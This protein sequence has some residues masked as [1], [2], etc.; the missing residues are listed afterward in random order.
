MSQL[1]ISLVHTTGNP[2]S[3]NAAQSLGQAA[4]LHE[5]I[6]TFGYG[7][8]GLLKAFMSCLPKTISQYLEAE[9]SRRTWIVPP[10]GVMKNHPGREI[11]RVVLQK[12]PFAQRM[13]LDYKTLILWLC[14]ALDRHVADHHLQ[15]LDAIYSYEDI[16]ATTF[17]TAKRQGIYCLYELPIVFYRTSQAIQKLEAER[18]PELASALQ[19]AQE[20]LWKLKRKDQEVQLADHI[21]VASSFTKQSLQDAGVSTDKISVVPYGAP[22]DY[23]YPRPKP[24]SDFRALYVGQVS[25]RKGIQYLLQAWQELQLS[26]AELLLVGVNCFPQPWLSSYE[27]LF[28]HIPSVPHHDLN[29]YYSLASVFVFPSLVEGFGLVLLEAMACGI[30]VITTP[31]TAGPDILTDG[32]EGFI[33]PIRDVNALKEKLEWCYCH[34]TEL[35]EMGRAARHRAEQLTWD[36]YRQR[37]ANQVKAVLA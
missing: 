7:Q 10:G 17:Q 33:I 27:K 34:P 16:A 6:T 28:R 32:V 3:R 15:G 29:Q 19:A 14:T 23:F 35:A 24:D 11:I 31:H 18:F 2:N 1:R 26:A 20:P 8:D 4:L 21:F 30:P 37:L 36:L 25:P 13:G 22:T 12:L 5:V 9:L